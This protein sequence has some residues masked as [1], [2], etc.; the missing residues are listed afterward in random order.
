MRSGRRLAASVL[1]LS[2]VAGLTTAC[3]DE[4]ERPAVRSAAAAFLTAWSDGALDKAAASTDTPAAANPF[5]AEVTESLAVTKIRAEAGRVPQPTDGRARVPYTMTLTLRGLGDWSYT[6]TLPMQR[7][8][9]GDTSR[10]V[11]RWSPAVVHP[12]LTAETRFGRS[13]SLPARAAILDRDGQALMTERPVVDIG[14]EPRRLTAPQRAYRA[15]ADLDVDPAKLEARVRAAKPDHFVPAITLRREQFAKDED[16]LRA[17][18]GLVFRDETRTLAP[19]PT[20]GRAVLGSVREAT[21]E[22][23][24]KAGPLAAATDYLGAS[25][26]QLAFQD[27][28]AGRPSGEVHL[29][30][31]ATTEVVEVLHSFDGVEGTPLRTTLDRD[32]QAAAERA[33]AGATKPAALVAVR[34]STGEVL[35]AANAPADSA[36]DRALV[37]QYP[38]GS[39]FK[40]VSASALF[41]DGLKPNDV[42]ACPPSVTVDGK[43]FK[44]YDDLGSLGRVPFSRDFA[45][46]CNT[47]FINATQRLEPDAIS[48]TAALFGIGAEW[49][50]GVG[51]FSGSVPAA[52]SDV[53][54]A[55]SAIGQG[56]VLMSPLAMAVVAAAIQS[57]TPRSPS[58]VSQGEAGNKLEPLPKD[59]ARHGALAHA[60]HRQRRHGQGAGPAGDAG[61]CQD[62]DGG[63]R[64]RVATAHPCLDGRLPRR[65]GVR[66]PRRGRPVGQ[67][68]GGADRQEV[69]PVGDLTSDPATQQV[70]A[71]SAPQHAGRGPRALGQQP[72]GHT[73][74]LGPS[75]P[76]T[77]R[78]GCSPRAAAARSSTSSRRPETNSGCVPTVAAR[79][80]GRPSRSAV[81]SASVSRS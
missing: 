75:A 46:S 7:V 68:D 16:A 24:A 20:Y 54:K 66:R 61:R 51:S 80:Q 1:A 63:V 9:D 26:L 11:V 3:S 36:F 70:A 27:E 52:E 79:T 76:S 23:L 53:D 43:R 81:A 29:L 62:R 39:T 71:Q 42:V 8:G 30:N 6:A 35:A 55:A 38:P 5:L 77:R 45:M 37:G 50:L 2:V 14:I 47:A 15:L 44:N 22:T 64:H 57:G 56:K 32:L 21:A 72:A 67:Q 19:T 17:I 49:D 33:L 59:V 78:T 48:Q 60:G 69:P 40:V 18:P 4:D 10:W 12:K 34:P 74:W 28:L 13:R 41:R 58:L 25:G 65:P 31:R 73:S